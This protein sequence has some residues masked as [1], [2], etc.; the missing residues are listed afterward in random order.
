M[1]NVAWYSSLR[2]I[3][4]KQMNKSLFT[5]FETYCKIENVYLLH[6]FYMFNFNIIHW[7]VIDVHF[8]KLATRHVRMY[9]AHHV[10]F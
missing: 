7:N 2:S 4:A 6:I 9:L 8:Q 1:A 10:Y 3:S 5:P